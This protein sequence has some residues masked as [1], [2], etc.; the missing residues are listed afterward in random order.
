[1]LDLDNTNTIEK[2]EVK[3][4]IACVL[5]EDPTLGLSSHEVDRIIERVRDLL[6]KQNIRG[7]F[8]C[9]LAV[10]QAQPYLSGFLPVAI[11]RSQT[12]QAYPRPLLTAKAKL[13]S[14]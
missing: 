4:A 13:T 11:A 7:S 10:F 12:E 3:R 6:A 8:K 2:D 5:E 14:L 1:M 9:K